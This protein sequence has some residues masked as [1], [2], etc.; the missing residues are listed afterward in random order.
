MVARR[1]VSGDI[2]PGGGIQLEDNSPSRYEIAVVAD[3]LKLLRHVFTTGAI[4]TRNAAEFLDVSRSTAYRILLTL[5]AQGFVK[6]SDSSQ[7]WTPGYQPS[8]MVAGLI[9]ETL[10][11][12][13][14]PSMRRLLA[15]M[16]ETV[17]LGVYTNG[18]VRFVRTME[19]AFPLRM[20]DL[21]G[22]NAPLHASA[23]GKA[24]LAAHTPEEC[25]S[26]VK[27][28]VL[29]PITTETITHP[30][31]L[32]ADLDLARERGWAEDRSEAVP[33]ATCFGAAILGL[34][35][36]PLGALSVSVPDVRL[37]PELAAIAGRRIM[38][39]AREISAALELPQADGR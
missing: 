20:S 15:E 23:L 7:V 8:G 27:S 11:S 18:E 25:Q 33:G 12:V 24:V 37:T 2:T 14:A 21:P 29:T 6:R 5:A 26:I 17:N 31:A 28:L 13:A 22:H 16:H 38:Q 1:T 39:E 30:D 35:D 3:S 9:D 36:E 10:Q 34:G 19:S 32:L 4:S